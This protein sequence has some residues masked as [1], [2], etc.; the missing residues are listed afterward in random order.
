MV[1]DAG[2]LCFVGRLFDLLL[3]YVV[4]LPLL[5]AGLVLV[6]GLLCVWLWLVLGVV[7]VV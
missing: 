3:L 2:L 1:A 6:L 4:G 7:V 5:V